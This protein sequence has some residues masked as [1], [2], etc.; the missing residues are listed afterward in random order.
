M[1]TAQPEADPIEVHTFRYAQAMRDFGKVLPRTVSNV[2]DLKMLMRT[3]GNIGALY[4]RAKGAS[5]KGE[6][7]LQIRGCHTEV[8]TTRYWL[9]LVDG[10]AN[11]EIEMRRNRL[12]KASE[13]L[14]QVFQ[15]ILQNRP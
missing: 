2:E 1:A 9:R 3:S 7:I 8:Q 12:L 4:I 10:Q 14:I 6:Y 11:P 15:Q 5:N 13:E